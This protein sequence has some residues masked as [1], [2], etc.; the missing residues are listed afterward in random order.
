MTRTTSEPYPYPKFCYLG[1]TLGVRGGVEEATRAIVRCAWAKFK[2]L[3]PILT[4][5]GASYHIKGK[6]YRAC[7]QSM[8]TYGTETW[9]MKAENL[10][11]LERTEQMMVRWMCVVEG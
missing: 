6:I 5:R 11:S 9:A 8:L 3:F 10:H 1:D 7:V 2:E 4:A